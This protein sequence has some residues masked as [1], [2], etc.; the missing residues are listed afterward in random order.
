MMFGMPFMT[1]FETFIYIAFLKGITKKRLFFFG[2]I[3]GPKTKNNCVGNTLEKNVKMLISKLKKTAYQTSSNRSNT[4]FWIKK[5]KVFCQS[6]WLRKLYNR[7]GESV[8]NI[9]TLFWIKK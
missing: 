5:S 8:K 1:N 6:V 4:L 3:L 2:S 9:D 7:R